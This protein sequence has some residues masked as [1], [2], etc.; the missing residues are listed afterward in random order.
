MQN[1]MICLG[2]VLDLEAKTTTENCVPAVLFRLGVLKVT[3]HLSIVI[4]LLLA[5]N[6]HKTSQK[7]PLCT[8]RHNR[9]FQGLP[10]SSSNH[11]WRARSAG[12]VSPRPI[13][14]RSNHIWSWSRGQILSVGNLVCSES[15]KWCHM[16]KKPSTTMDY[17]SQNPVLGS[18][19]C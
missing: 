13:K 15:H 7:Q 4:L 17:G 14:D 9:H 11:K 2:P 10:F 6:I 1:K 5:K 16:K 19:T 18:L 12:S 8:F 3:T